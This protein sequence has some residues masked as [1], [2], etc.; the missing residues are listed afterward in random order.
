VPKK[1]ICAVTGS[2]ADYG[3]LYWVM[4]E[5]AAHPQLELQ[6]AATGM[7]FSPRHGETWRVI[8]QDGF[9]LDARVETAP[10]DDS[11]L[12][13][14][15]AVAA[16]VGG[17]AD[18]F[19]RLAPDV[20][21]VLGDRF[22]ILAAAQAAFL[23]NYP[24][25]HIAG[26]DVTEGAIDDAM[27]HA[28]SKMA[29]L[30]F[31]T[32][33]VAAARLRRMGE[34]PARIF[35][36]GSPGLDT[37]RKTKLMSRAELEAA[38]G[39]RLGKRLFLVTFHPATL[40]AEPPARQFGELLAALE[41]F[42][43]DGESSIVFTLPNADPGNA[44]IAA[45]IRNY[46]A[47]AP[48]ARAF[49]SL[50]Q[51]KYLSAMAQAAAVVGNSSSGLYEAP[52]LKRPSVNIGERQKGR[53]MADSVVSCAPRADAIAAAIERALAL[54]CSRTVNPYGD[55]NSAARIVARLAAIERPR[56]LLRKR[57]VDGP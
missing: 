15:R 49:D 44:A 11:P 4:K 25:A 17:F 40:E 13:M 9:R 5:I 3:L 53:L 54:D 31:P 27:R 1:T 16:G 24:L 39:M 35:D 34:E 18:A 47:A 41:R 29:H 32:N 30:H 48:N 46:V 8:E 20:V 21:L 43:G 2:R 51:L 26:G 7:H 38:L 37:I 56:E 33:A 19:A 42:S 22:E 55:G 12:A 52:T 45:L 36:V 6:V 50:G 57:F 10:Q 28:I 23:G 14:T